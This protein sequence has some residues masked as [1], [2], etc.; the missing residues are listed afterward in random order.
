MKSHPYEIYEILASYLNQWSFY[1]TRDL[2]KTSPS[3][4]DSEV[5]MRFNFFYNLKSL[6]F[7]NGKLYCFTL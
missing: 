5:H 3:P 2:I 7:L 6:F 1:K 4:M